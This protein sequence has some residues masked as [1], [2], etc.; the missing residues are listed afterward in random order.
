MD[1]FLIFC[2]H[3]FMTGEAW[4]AVVQA[5]GPHLIST[6]IEYHRIRPET[7]LVTKLHELCASQKI[8]H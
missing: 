7:A 1:P 3:Y 2:N 8:V 5:S 4:L 6:L